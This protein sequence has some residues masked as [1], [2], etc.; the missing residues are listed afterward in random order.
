[1]KGAIGLGLPTVSTGLLSLVM[2]PANAA[3]LLIAPSGAIPD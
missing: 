3:S 2:A 1:V